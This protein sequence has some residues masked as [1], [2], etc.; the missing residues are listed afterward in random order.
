M[1]YRTIEL[2]GCQVDLWESEC[3]DCGFISGLAQVTRPDGTMR[4]ITGAGCF[5]KPKRRGPKETLEWDR[6]AAGL[7]AT[8]EPD[9]NILGTPR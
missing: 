5:S 7:P 3:K 2:N 4:M 8:E 1:N 9:E 6:I